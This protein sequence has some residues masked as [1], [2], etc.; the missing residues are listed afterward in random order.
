MGM[1]IS[2]GEAKELIK[3]H[4]EKLYPNSESITV[5]Y[6]LERHSELT[7]FYNGDSDFFNVYEVNAKITISNKVGN[8]ILKGNFIID[9][10]EMTDILQEELSILYNSDEQEVYYVSLQR[11]ERDRINMSDEIYVEMKKNKHKQKTLK[12]VGA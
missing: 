7:T 1:V 10:E 2:Y 6:F 4:Y 8:S 12:K 5:K 3:H 9:E 11:Q